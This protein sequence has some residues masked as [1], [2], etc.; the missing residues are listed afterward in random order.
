MPRKQPPDGYLTAKEAINILGINE[1]M[2]YAYVRNGSLQRIVP[3]GRKQGFYLKA[4]VEAFAS[5]LRGFFEGSEPD[6]L[7]VRDL[8]FAQATPDDMEGVYK[9]ALSLFGK[10]TSAEARK[11]I[12]A[13]CPEG[14]YIVRRLKRNASGEVVSK[15]TVAYIHIQPLKHDRLIAFMNGEIRG[16]DITSDDLD[17]F[18]PGKVVNCL[19]KS[20]GAYNNVGLTEETRRYNHDRFMYVLLKGTVAELAKM[21][22][23]GCNIEKFYATSETLTGI[24]MAHNAGMKDFGKPFREGRFRYVLDVQESDLSLL[25]PY[26]RALAE[27]QRKAHG[28]GA[29]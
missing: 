13:R 20:V 6:K 19:V 1:G 24:R 17:P 11:P 9:V 23:K 29:A 2:L 25:I 3:A 10:T 12:V 21:G 8:E 22:S 27:Y 5:E 16:K 28:T 4:Q 14:N 18:E 26:K 15:T 7:S